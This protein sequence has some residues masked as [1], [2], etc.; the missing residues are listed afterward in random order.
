M[1]STLTVSMSL[2]L[3]DAIF[4]GARRLHPKE[5]ILMLRGKKSKDVIRINDLVIPPLATYGQGFAHYPLY[6]LPTDF[7]LMGTVHSH[8][9]GNTTPSNVDFNHFFGRIMMIVGYPY[10]S[11]QDV[12]VYNCQGEKL[13]FQITRE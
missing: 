10:A 5:T 7:S 2:E 11:Q 9:S 1:A 4:E 3:L 8:P 12:S 6:M 13:Q